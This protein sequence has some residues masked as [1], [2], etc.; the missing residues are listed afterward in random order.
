[1]DSEKTVATAK[2]EASPTSLDPQTAKTNKEPAPVKMPKRLMLL[3]VFLVMISISGLMAK[4][5]VLFCILTLFMVLA[6]IGK[7]KAGLLMLRVYTSLQLII[8]SALPIMLQDPDNMVPSEPSSYGIGS[9]SI[10]L[11]DWV[12][13]GLLIIISLVQV[14]I[15]FT[16]K[17]SRY[18]SRALNL[19]IMR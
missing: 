7:Q 1:M 18:F 15:A 11:P 19:N 14:W 8:A 17:V 4:Q 13:F 6:I 5:G 9:F 10:Q 12:V 16:P 2:P 3:L